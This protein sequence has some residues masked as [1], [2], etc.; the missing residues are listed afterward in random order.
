VSELHLYVSTINRPTDYC[1]ARDAALHYK[2]AFAFV[3][4]L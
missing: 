4:T 2:A 1:D 3:L